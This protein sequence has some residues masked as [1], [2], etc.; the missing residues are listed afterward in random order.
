MP[1]KKACLRFLFFI[2]SIS[3]LSGCTI[4]LFIKAEIAQKHQGESFIK[5]KNYLSLAQ[6]WD[7]NAKKQMID[8]K[9]ASY[10]AIWEHDKKAEITIGNGPYYGLIELV[11]LDNDTTKITY[12]A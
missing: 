3:V 12:Y 11:S 4:P 7:N 8:F 10:L 1:T 5:K 6:Y 2:I 9:S